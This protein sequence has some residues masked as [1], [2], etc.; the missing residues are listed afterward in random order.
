MAC[1]CALIEKYSKTD[2][3]VVTNLKQKWLINKGTCAAHR[4][5]EIISDT[6]NWNMNDSAR[7]RIEQKTV[8]GSILNLWQICKYSF[9]IY[10]T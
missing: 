3:T 8:R 1:I 5:G 6:S 10:S 7:L 4:K 9:V 2:K